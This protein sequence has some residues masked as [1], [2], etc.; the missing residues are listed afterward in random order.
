MSTG[1]TWAKGPWD[2]SIAL[3]YHTG[4][5]TTTVRLV[6]P[7][8]SSPDVEIGQRNGNRL[9]AFASLDLRVSR[10]FPLRIGELTA[11][12][13]VTN[14]L[15]RDNPCCVDYAVTQDGP[16][17]RLLRDAQSWLPVVPSIGVLW[18]F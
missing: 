14:A 18:K 1:V 15:N 9:E 2:A 12:A 16:P 7:D 6:T 8:G 13:E 10:T 3:A 11:H 4:W 5:P 17:Y